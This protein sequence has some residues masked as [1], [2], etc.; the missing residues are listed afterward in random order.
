[1]C[2]CPSQ[3]IEIGESCV[4]LTLLLPSI[5]V[6]IF[7]VGLLA[8][9]AYGKFKHTA[10]DSVWKIGFRDLKFPATPEI[11]GIGTF[12]VVIRAEYYGTHVA[13][14]RVIPVVANPTTG[15]VA[16]RQAL[17][18]ALSYFRGERVQSKMSGAR[19][20]SANVK[21]SSH[22]DVLPASETTFAK[23][24]GGDS[25]SHSFHQDTT[26][27]NGSQ[28]P[29]QSRGQFYRVNSGDRDF[30]QGP[31]PAMVRPKT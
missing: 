26:T 21:G 6:P 19:R 22:F 12:G 24:S 4:Q 8:M 2:T 20:A 17:N 13:V 14:K 15:R 1:M 9:F 18:N 11:L 16:P 29:L 30:P 7:F 3:S 10:A 27:W 5:I 25:S 23:I 28:V 31:L